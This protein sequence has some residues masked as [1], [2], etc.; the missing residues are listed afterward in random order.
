LYDERLLG[1]G[2]PL[3]LTLLLPG[4]R[5]ISRVFWL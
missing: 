4:W 5:L 2:L 1:S 3:A